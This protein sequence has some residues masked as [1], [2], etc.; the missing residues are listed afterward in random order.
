MCSTHMHMFVHLISTLVFVLRG[1]HCMDG[2]INL[3]F[4]VATFVDYR[5]WRDE[6]FCTTD[7]SL[8]LSLSLSH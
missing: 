2:C 7:F 1:D 4:N 8:S 6:A 5:F 3:L